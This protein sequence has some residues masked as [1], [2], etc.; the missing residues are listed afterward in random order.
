MNPKGKKNKPSSKFN[1]TI[2][3]IFNTLFVGM[4]PTQ[5]LKFDIIL[6]GIDSCH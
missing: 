1:G 4:V 3:T 6:I 2:G 5:P